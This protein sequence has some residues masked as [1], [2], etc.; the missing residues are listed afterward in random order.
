MHPGEK[1]VLD[2]KVMQTLVS[3]EKLVLC[4]SLTR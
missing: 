1:L 3:A 4:L 2:L